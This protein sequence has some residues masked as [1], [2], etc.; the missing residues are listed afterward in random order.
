[1]FFPFS[2]AVPGRTPQWSLSQTYTL[3][4]IEIFVSSKNATN[5]FW[6]GAWAL[7]KRKV[8]KRAYK[9]PR[10]WPHGLWINI[11]IRAQLLTVTDSLRK[12]RLLAAKPSRDLRFIKLWPATLKNTRNGKSVLKISK[13]PSLRPLALKNEILWGFEFLKN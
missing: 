5:V 9:F 2:I 6:K 10:S 7:I 3:Y 1:M 4:I 8:E 12:D 11:I 13:W